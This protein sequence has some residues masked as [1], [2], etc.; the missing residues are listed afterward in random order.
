MQ[1]KASQVFPDR[2]SLERMEEGVCRVGWVL[3]DVAHLMH[4]MIKMSVVVGRLFPIIFSAALT[5]L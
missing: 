3:D 5:T 1:I 2:T 4:L